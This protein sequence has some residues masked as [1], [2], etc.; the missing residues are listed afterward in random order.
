MSL[1]LG[2]LIARA[3]MDTTQ[4]DAGATRVQA[5]MKSMAT[6]FTQGASSATQYDR[7]VATTSLSSDKAAVSIDRAAAAA[8][9][10]AAADERATASTQVYTQAQGRVTAIMADLAGASARVQ[11]TELRRLATQERL[12][13][14]DATAADAT[15]ALA[16]E[17]SRLAGAQASAIGAAAAAQKAQGTVAASM[18][19]TGKKM[20]TAITLPVAAIAAFSAKESVDFQKSMTLLETAGGETAAKLVTISAGVKQVAIETGTTLSALSEGM[21][22]VAKGGAQKWSASDQLLVLKAAA[23]G[24]KAENVDLATATNALTSVMLGYGLSAKDAVSA[25]NMM[26]RGSGLAKTTFSD[27]AKSLSNVVPLASSLHISFA[28][29]AGAIAT[30]T[31][32]GESAQ[33]ST[34]NLN[35]L[36][37]NLAGQ[38][39]V[40]RQAMEQL[41]LSAV[42]IQKNLGERGLTGTLQMVED[43]LAKNSKA[44]ELVVGAF[45]QSAS[46]GASMRQML[47]AM[48]G[49]LKTQSQGLANGSVGIKDYTKYAKSMGGEQGAMALQFLSLYKNTEGFSNALKSGNGQVQSTAK[50]LQQM[51]GGATGL[52]VALMLG[53]T[54]AGQFRSNVDQVSKAAKTAGSDVLGWAETQDTLAVKLDKA[55]VAAQVLAVNVGGTVIPM[56]TKVVGWVTQGV[57]AFEGLSHTDKVIIAWSLA[58]LAAVGPVLTIFGKVALLGRGLSTV[59]LTAGKGFSYLTTGSTAMS[60]GVS[61]AMSGVAAAVGG[62]AIG[63]AFGALTANASSSV[64]AVSALASTALGA[65]QGF[66]AGGA[67][68]GLIGGAAG[69]VAN[70]ATA[71][72]VSGDKVRY[73]ASGIEAYTQAVQRDSDAIGQN[74]RQLVANDLA[75]GDTFNAARMLGIDPKTLTDAALGVQSAIDKVRALA[76]TP[77][78]GKTGLAAGN[79][80]TALGLEDST[81]AKAKQ[82]AADIADA[83]STAGK[84]DAARTAALKALT[85]QQDAYT[86]GLSALNVQVG[87]YGTN[88]DANTKS[89]QSNLAWL[90]KQIQAAN[91]LA[92]SQF[93]AGT[94]LQQTTTGLGS[95]LAALKAQA[96]QAGLNGDVLDELIAKYK[97]TPKQIVTNMVANIGKA[98]A[99]ASQLQRI[100]DAIKQNHVPGLQAN[101]AQ[102]RADVAALQ[103]RI[104]SLKGK[105]VPVGVKSDGSLSWFSSWLDQITKPRTVSVS[106]ATS[107]TS[108][109]G[110][111]IL[112]H[113]SGHATGGVISGRGT[114]TSDSIPIMASNGEFVV[115]ASQARRYRWLLEA[116]NSGRGYASGGVVA[117]SMTSTKSSITDTAQLPGVKGVAEAIAGQTGPAAAAMRILSQAVNDAFDLRGIGTKITNAK[118]QLTSMQQY[119]GTVTQTLLGAFD[120][121]KYGSMADLTAGVSGATAVN[122][123][124]SAE[125]AKLHKEVKYNS[126]LGKFIDQLAAQGQ[127]ATLQTLAGAS[128][129]DL[130]RFAKTVGSYNA[131]VSAGG[132]AAVVAHFGLSTTQQSKD[133]ASLVNLQ[134]SALQRVDDLVGAVSRLTGRPAQIVVDGK[135]IAH[136]VVEPV[137][138]HVLDELNNNRLY[139]R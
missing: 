11:Q 54:S 56:V 111:A 69:L 53:G 139:R 137:V 48:T 75:K 31:Q 88:L 81:V 6:T 67:I 55:K 125:L 17:T 61:K 71:F 1:D 50:A 122:S 38:N 110:A 77:G 25:E 101:S 106:V 135:V 37:R 33:Q 128:T 43:A 105:Q 9:K 78:L 130:A 100:I 52:N 29:V 133:V 44:G 58:V 13:A 97:A 34:D 94:S 132:E 119:K 89:G 121:T 83:M 114:G 65:V 42:D 120:P 68:G 103:E 27:F 95:N 127:T 3:V 85:A 87:V 90:T 51:L 102:G 16:A 73:A 57:Q 124:Y 109:L 129:G 126:P 23:Q 113:A 138:I 30:M 117:T 32:H 74:V 10:K 86:K 107:G 4:F 47:A 92:K 5:R 82:N 14:V 96:V 40:A 19:A 63:A 64:R 134:K 18:L 15:R 21:Y 8:S 93:T 35:N 45:R 26:I 36:I 136:T 76:G 104:N 112:G 131:S 115:R 99:S 62:A 72:G 60:A 123:A 84:N 98:T 2:A 59:F 46:A 24:A 118:A 80:L 20:S 49:D 7:A 28:Q 116:I 79:V 12:T 66:A 22:I 39:N 70:L 41:G 91:D 108:G